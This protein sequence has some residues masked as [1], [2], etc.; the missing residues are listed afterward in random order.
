MPVHK[1]NS[2]FRINI[3]KSLPKG[4]TFCGLVHREGQQRDGTSA[5]D[6]LAQLT[7]MLGAVAGHTAGQDLAALV[8]ETTQT[9]DVLVVDVFDLIHTEGAHLTAG[10]AQPQ[11]GYFVSV[12]SSGLTAPSSRQRCHCLRRTFDPSGSAGTG[13]E[14]TAAVRFAEYANAVCAD[15]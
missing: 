5:L 1:L 3:K 4:E 10:A 12:L 6:G 2:A 8:D 11:V 13:T 9:V 15:A 14:S 7:L